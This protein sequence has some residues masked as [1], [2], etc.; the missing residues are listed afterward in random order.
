M[1]LIKHWIAPV[2]FLTL[3]VLNATPARAIIVFGGM[4]ANGNYTGSG[5]NLDPAPN[6]TGG[7]YSGSL[8]NYEGLFGDYLG[9]PIGPRSF[10]SAQHLGEV[11]PQFQY[12]NG[13]GTT[14]TYNIASYAYVPN[15]DLIVYSIAANDPA[16]TLYAPL[17]TGSDEVGNGLVTLGRGPGRGGPIMGGYGEMND[18]PPNPVTWGTGTVAAAGNLIPDGNG[19]FISFQFAQNT[20]L[21]TGIFAPGDSGGATFVKD[22]ADGV[23]KLA[24]VNSTVDEVA[25]AANGGPVPLALYDARGYFDPTTHQEITG[26][27]PIPLSSYA[28]RISTSYSFLAQ[29]TVPE[30]GGLALAAVGGLGMAGL[31]RG[32][33]LRRRAAGRE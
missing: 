11:S 23:Y 6:Q 7:G 4:D 21:N 13:T 10:I 25:T 24:G 15:S 22:P 29:Y 1:T 8:S 17:Y 12:N 31:I 20:G 14:T 30:P 28:S 33:K 9:T 27:D 26:P 18:T 19:Q 16:F 3:S 32:G 2:A 5:Q